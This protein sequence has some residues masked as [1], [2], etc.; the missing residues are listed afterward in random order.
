MK[1]IAELEI[2]DI[3]GRKDRARKKLARLPFGEKIK[4]VEAMRDRAE[5]FRRF[6]DSRIACKG[7]SAET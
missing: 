5:L 4:I 3:L 7:R 6:R 1:E 2:S